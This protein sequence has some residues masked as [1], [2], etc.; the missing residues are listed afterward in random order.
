M[1]V[2][3]YNN[4]LPENKETDLTFLSIVSPQVFVRRFDSTIVRGVDHLVIPFYVTDSDMKEYTEDKVGYTF[5]TIIRID[6]D[7]VDDADVI[8]WKMTT[9]AGEFVADLGTFVD[10]GVHTLSIRT[11]QSNGVGSATKFYK[12]FVRKPDSEKRSIDLDDITG[13]TSQ[14]TDYRFDDMILG[15]GYYVPAKIVYNA[16]YVVTVSKDGNGDVTDIQIV[17]SALGST[18]TVQQLWTEDSGEVHPTR[19]TSEPL[20]SIDIEGTYH[21]ATTCTVNGNV[22]KLSDYL[23]V[24]VDEVPSEVY[25]TAASNKV[26]LTRL[27]EAAKAKFVQDGDSCGTDSLVMPNK[28]T[29]VLDYR[30][31]N[32]NKSNSS[33]VVFK[34]RNDV[35]FPNGITIDLN[36]STVAMLPVNGIKGGRVFHIQNRVDTHMVNGYTVGNWKNFNYSSYHD[37][38]TLC[39]LVIHSSWFCSFED[40]DAS[41]VAGYELHIGNLSVA[42]S[43]SENNDYDPWGQGRQNTEYVPFTTLGYIDYE[44]NIHRMSYTDSNGVV[45]ADGKLFAT[46]TSVNHA[47]GPIMSL[48]EYQG[49]QLSYELDG[50]CKIRNY[51]WP[52]CGREIRVISEQ[53]AYTDIFH[54]LTVREMFVHFY[55]LDNNFIKTVKVLERWPII[56]P[57][58]AWKMRMTRYGESSIDNNSY[59]ALNKYG[60]SNKTR[61][62][63]KYVRNFCD[64]SWG[65]GV[66]RC[67]IHDM[68]TCTLD[69]GGV[70]S[71]VKDCI[72]WNVAA[73][74]DG[75]ATR[76]DGDNYYFT[77]MLVDCED[78]SQQLFNMCMDNCEFLFGNAKA[79]NM[80]FGYD[81]TITNCRNLHFTQWHDVNGGLIENCSGS[82]AR[83]QNYK[84]DNARLVI[85]NCMLSSLENNGSG[86][87]KRGNDSI[88]NLWLRHNVV[89]RTGG[90]LENKIHDVNNIKL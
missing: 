82:F 28:M 7:T 2:N 77:I 86:T 24:N 61:I 38:E 39:M 21:I 13:F 79:V 56:I 68:R 70:Q 25:L 44:G 75:R 53:Q 80:V 73:E 18:P 46:E 4:S 60:N 16:K 15:S 9:Y 59:D 35:L 81:Y 27:F 14:F 5:T 69:N 78:D 71:T 26:A 55:D 83:Y 63:G 8:E 47:A 19:N 23:G 64:L 40:L 1:I 58:G 72:F 65:C 32:G 20:P 85:R 37:A 66:Y 76:Y 88:G 36:Q 48:G 90:S 43:I 50:M 33:D 12:F 67:K 42:M 62:Y 51:V 54:R 6:E 49:G 41:F 34:G 87:D 31:I 74:R 17:V 89:S 57:K 30:D 29:I 22:V 45:H 52:V 3:D 11:I 84:T 10:E